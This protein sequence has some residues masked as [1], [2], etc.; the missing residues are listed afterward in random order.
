MDPTRGCNVEKASGSTWAEE[1]DFDKRRNSREV[2]WATI[3][4]L[5]PGRTDNAIKNHWNSTLRRKRDPQVGAESKRQRVEVA[6]SSESESGVIKKE[7]SSGVVSEQEE[8]GGVETVLTLLP[9]GKVM[10]VP[11]GGEREGEDQVRKG[12]DEGEIKKLMRCT[13]GRDDTCLINVMQNM[14]AAEVKSYID[15]LVLQPKSGD[16][17]A[18]KSD[19]ARHSK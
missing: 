3:A 10:D 11:R 2:R 16:E 5:L 18:P 15:R 14:I 7:V 17:N 1:L 12:D 4:K 13:V 9:P 6:V 19:S 8:D